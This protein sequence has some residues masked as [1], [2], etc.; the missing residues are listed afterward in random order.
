MSEL[1]QGSYLLVAHRRSIS[2]SSFPIP[3]EAVIQHDYFKSHLAQAIY[4]YGLV[5]SHLWILHMLC[6]Q[7]FWLLLGM[8]IRLQ[9][10]KLKNNWE[11][12]WGSVAFCCHWFPSQGNCF[13]W[14]RGI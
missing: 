5:N 10:L 9:N 4:F 3:T 13:W 11:G 1:V 14:V 7:S 6:Q 2:H 8:S 12:I